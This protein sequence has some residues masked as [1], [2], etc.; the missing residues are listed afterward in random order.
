LI[1]AAG[2]NP[3][4]HVVI[5]ATSSKSVDDFKDAT[6]LFWVLEYL[7]FPT[8]SILD[9]GFAK[10]QAEKREVQ[11]QPVEP[12]PTSLPNLK[13]REE[14][15]A[16]AEK[17]AEAE[18]SKDAALLDCRSP[19]EFAGSKKNDAVAKA[20]H[21]PGAVSL[22][23]DAMLDPARNTV[24]P[25]K[26]KKDLEALGVKPE[27]PA[28]AYC[29][30]GRQASVG[31]FTLRMLGKNNVALYDGSMSDWTSRPERPVEQGQADAAKK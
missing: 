27:E 8:V 10:W 11:T 14:L 12:K 23:A 9:G 24:A 18:K 1:E 30:T 3:E 16:N 15:R 2:L 21:V 4:Q 6:R 28:I 5:Y 22:P 13:P 25:D 7:G 19:E 29:N 17:V 20:G 26:T 31:Y